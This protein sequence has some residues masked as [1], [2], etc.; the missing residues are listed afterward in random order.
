MR[1]STEACT[2][3]I[4]PGADFRQSRGT[5]PPPG[6]VETAPHSEIEIGVMR[7]RRDAGQMVG[8]DRAE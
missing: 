5:A 1:V 4:M 3:R 6:A 8:E 2:S 7:R